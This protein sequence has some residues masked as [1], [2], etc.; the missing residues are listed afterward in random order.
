M[1]DRDP[2]ILPLFAR[3]IWEIDQKKVADLGMETQVAGL[4]IDSVAMLEVIGFLEDELQVHLPE[5]RL[6]DV[7]TVG[8]LADVIAAARA[9]D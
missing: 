5:E 4:G 9:A 2:Q 6:R 8:D 7:V 1:T 3:A